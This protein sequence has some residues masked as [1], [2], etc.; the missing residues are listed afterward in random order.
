MMYRPLT[1][2]V[3]YSFS[4]RSVEKSTDRHLMCRESSPP[5]VEPVVEPP[6]I[7]GRVVGSIQIVGGREEALRLRIGVSRANRPEAFELDCPLAS[8]RNSSPDHS[9]NE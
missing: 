3:T 2:C 5:R 4:R 7:P 6:A 9:N 8:R 1:Y